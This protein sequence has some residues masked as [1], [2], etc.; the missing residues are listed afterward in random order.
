MY[1]HVHSSL[2]R[3]R[4]IKRGEPGPLQPFPRRLRNEVR[5]PSGQTGT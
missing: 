2:W 4:G 3:D 5:F 1:R